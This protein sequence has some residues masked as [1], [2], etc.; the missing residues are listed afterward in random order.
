M[1]HLRGG[2]LELEWDEATK[3]VFMTGPAAEVFTGRI[4][5]EEGGER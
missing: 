1:N 5:I 2:D 4:E 3:H